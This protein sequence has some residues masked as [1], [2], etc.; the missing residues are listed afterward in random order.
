MPPAMR[1]VTYTIAAPILRRFNA[2]VPRGE[3]GRVVEDLMMQAVAAREA[4][5]ECL[6][7]AFMTD[8]AFAECRADAQRGLADIEVGRAYEADAAIAQR[9]GR[10]ANGA[11]SVKGARKFG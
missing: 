8:P 9:Q 5:V 4:E 10:R 11:A 2:L 7:E 1:R 6:A 3:R